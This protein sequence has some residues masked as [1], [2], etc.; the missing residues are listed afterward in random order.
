MQ[1]RN[2]V[3]INPL[4]GCVECCALQANNVQILVLAEKTTST[5]QYYQQLQK[6]VMLELGFSM[7][8][9]PGQAEAA[10]VLSQMVGAA[11]LYKQMSAQANQGYSLSA[12]TE[13]SFRRYLIETNIW[14]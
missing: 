11:C 8:P 14:K 1:L 9:V 4:I 2:K 13:I 10:G 5:A 12:N 3:F 6:F 7:L